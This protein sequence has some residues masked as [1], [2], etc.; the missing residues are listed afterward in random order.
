MATL[1]KILLLIRS[2][3]HLRPKGDRRKT[4]TCGRAA[5]PSPAP[6]VHGG[7]QRSPRTADNHR[8]AGRGNTPPPPGAGFRVAMEH[9]SAGQRFLSTCSH[10]IPLGR[11]LQVPDPQKPSGSSISENHCAA[12]RPVTNRVK[13]RPGFL[14]AREAPR[15][16][17][18]Q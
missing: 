9:L 18:Q 13:L 10:T 12:R 2:V 6:R 3:S 1:Y 4:S 7:A 17:Q 5:Q 8:G 15:K 16:Q 14:G 11:S